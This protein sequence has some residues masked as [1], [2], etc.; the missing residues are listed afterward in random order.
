MNND[1]LTAQAFLCAMV[2]VANDMSN[3]RTCA[4][5]HPIGTALPSLERA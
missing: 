2:K 4:L 1:T 5:S 3:N